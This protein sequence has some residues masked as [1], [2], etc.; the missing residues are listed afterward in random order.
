MTK[1]ILKPRKSGYTFADYFKLN[2]ETEEVVA[3]FDYSFEAAHCRLPQTKVAA[4][5][6]ADLRGRIDESLPFINLSNEVARREF[7]ISP[8]LLEVVSQTHA[9]I[10]VEYPLEVELNLKGTLDY[11]LRA[12]NRLLVIEAK[13]AD[14][15]RGFTQLAVELIALDKWITDK[16]RT[17][18]G[19][20]SIGDVWRFG[21]LD[22][23]K[24][25]ITQDLKLYPVPDALEGLLGI[26]IAILKHPDRAGQAGSSN[27]S[28]GRKK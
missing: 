27:R 1:K 20:I 5:R 8:V 3:F 19:A 11:F 24:K 22:R 7:L 17:L 13:N 12:D 23:R 14:L 16:S 2:L 18:Y 9:K 26:L 28:N 6:L 21:V 4:A 10:S 25:L 15:Q